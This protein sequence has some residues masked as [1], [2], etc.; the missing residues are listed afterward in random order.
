MGNKRI[1]KYI[2][3]T[4]LGFV[5]FAGAII[6]LILNLDENGIMKTLPYVCL[7]L[8][9]GIFGGSL[10]MVLSIRMLRKNVRV[11]KQAEIQEKDERNIAIRNKA[12]AKA[13]NSMILVF[14]ALMMGFALMQ[15]DKYVVLAFVAAYLF[16]VAT[17]IYYICKFQKEM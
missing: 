7:G 1:G 5:L 6:L 16:V 2:V 11:A 14:G 4:A 17:N 12:K 9:S 15:V 8:G 13:Y 10:S 3:F